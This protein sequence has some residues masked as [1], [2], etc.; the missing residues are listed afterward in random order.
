MDWSLRKTGGTFVISIPDGIDIPCK[1]LSLGNFLYYTNAF[2]ES[3]IP[4]AILEDEIFALCVAAPELVYQLDSLAAGI[5]SL[6]ARE[7][8]ASSGP[9]HVEDFNVALQAAREKITN[10][11]HELVLIIIQ[12]FPAYK[13]E[14]I[15][16]MTF[17][18]VME[19]VAQAE[20]LLMKNKIIKEP[21]SMYEKKPKAKQTS[22][23]IKEAWAAAERAA[24]E[25]S[26]KNA[27]S[28][29]Q[30]RKKMR[31]PVEIPVISREQLLQ[32]H[33]KIDF[34]ADNRE[35]FMHDGVTGDEMMD[36]ALIRYKALQLAE[37]VHPKFQ[38]PKK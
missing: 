30:E 34:S 14:D 33:D 25:I 17:E 20:A 24:S 12:A 15:Y 28:S 23:E 26:S 21:F 38:N 36:E 3:L 16:S 10:P 7:A 35:L 32:K 13:P 31:E 37:K 5:I 2:Q 18:R 11:I 29:Y 4:Q 9:N 27:N 1:Y 8:L 6:V 19:R 22:R